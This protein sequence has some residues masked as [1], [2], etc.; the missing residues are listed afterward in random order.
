MKKAKEYL[1]EFI[2][3]F[4]SISLAFLSENWREKMQDKEDYDLIL[5]E[6][7]ANLLL[8]SIEFVNDISFICLESNEAPGARHLCIGSGFCQTDGSQVAPSEKI[9]TDADGRFSARIIKNREP[10]ESL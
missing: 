7:H 2:V 9:K 8:D 4:I 5:N 6:I 10:A 1:I 3:I